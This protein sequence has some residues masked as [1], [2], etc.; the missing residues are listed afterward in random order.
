MGLAGAD[1]FQRALREY[2]QI[3]AYNNAEG[4]DLWRII[5]DVC[6]SKQLFK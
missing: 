3:Y 6:Y 1:N 2:L 4:D 5:Q